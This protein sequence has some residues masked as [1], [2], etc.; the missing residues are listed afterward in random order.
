MDY[1][2]YYKILGV[3]KNA[4]Q[5]EIKKSY[6]KLARE[7]HPD[8]NP[9]NA[10]AEARFK[11]IS[12]AYEVL[13]N[14]ESRKKY[15]Q[16]GSDWKRYQQQG[17]PGG[18]FD[19]WAN[20]GRG[21]RQWHSDFG[22]KGNTSDFSDFFSSFFGGGAQERRSR[23]QDLK[24]NLRISL[25]DAYSGGPTTFTVNGQSLRL[26]LKPGVEDGQTIKLK[27]KGAATRPGGEPGDL[28]L[29]FEIQP[30]PQFDRRGADLFL[31]LNVPLYTLVLGGDLHIPTLSGPVK[32]PVKP[33]TKNGETLRLKGK[34]MP[35]YGKK[36]FGNLYVTLSAELPSGL[37]AKERDLFSQLQKL[38]PI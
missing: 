27:G 8:V 32:V 36:E 23:G 17:A 15:D 19:Q 29:T 11:E 2:D 5:D 37:S 33:E 16:L 24:A 6:R 4:T 22:G 31:D 25:A 35:V 12:E 26:N 28:Y 3:A 18:G 21:G 30:H 1:K 34:G 10:A 38:R 7:N 9:G 13:S 14:P 20:A